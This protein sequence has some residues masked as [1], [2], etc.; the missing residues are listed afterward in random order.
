MKKTT[1]GHKK[2]RPTNEPID[3]ARLLAKDVMQ[4]D[5]LTLRPDDT[6]ESAVGLLEEY[7]VSG[8]PVLDGFGKILGV[9]SSTDVARR[10]HVHEGS[11]SVGRVGGGGVGPDEDDG[12]DFEDEVLD[13][14][15]YSPELFASAR[16]DEWM[17]H[18]LVSVAPE[19]TLAEVCRL[20]V[21]ESIHRVFVVREEALCGVIS[22]FDVV[23]LMA[24]E[25][26]VKR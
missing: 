8:A 6:V 7:H 11:V 19:A 23:R 16:V 2:A 12:I 1:K 14:E 22:T 5:V 24:A 26:E 20:M 4:T 3:P 25:S 9:L 17:S 10:E 18:R 13:S 15:G 21:A